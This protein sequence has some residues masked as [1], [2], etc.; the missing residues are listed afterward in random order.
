MVGWEVSRHPEWDL[1]FAAG[2]NIPEISA[3]CHAQRNTVWRHFQ[4]RER[5]EPGTRARHD[6]AAATRTTY[7]GPAQTW[8][9]HLADALTFKAAH[10]RLPDASDCGNAKKVHKWIQTQRRGHEAG[11]LKQG[12][13]AALDLLGDWIPNTAAIARQEALDGLWRTRLAELVTFVNNTGHDPR[14]K[15]FASDHEHTLGVWLHTQTQHRA[16]RT[17]PTWRMAALDAALPGWHSH[18]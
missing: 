17:L 18:Q 10:G 15:R 8:V 5:L 1:M 13:E 3:H 6:A 14:Y 11:T 9:Q 2:L 16:H 12:M 7:D 4:I